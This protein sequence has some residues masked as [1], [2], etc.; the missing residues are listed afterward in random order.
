MIHARIHDGVVEAQDPI[1]KAWEGHLVK[2]VP[3]TPDD[4]IPNLGKLIA[5]KHALGPTEY[6]PGER[7]MIE[8]ALDELNQFSKKAMEKLANGEWSRMI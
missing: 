5:A 8:R 4:E 7:E 1:P 3:L 2:L 6:E